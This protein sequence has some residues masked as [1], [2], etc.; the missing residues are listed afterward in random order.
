MS[1]SCRNYRFLP[2]LFHCSSKEVVLFFIKKKGFNILKKELLKEGG[3]D[4]ND[5]QMFTLKN[6]NAHFSFIS[7]GSLF[8]FLLFETDFNEVQNEY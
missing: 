8:I 7:K 1:V 4:M 3:K 6:I 5:Y 2:K